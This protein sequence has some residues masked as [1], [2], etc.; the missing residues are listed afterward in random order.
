MLGAALQK[1]LNEWSFN[2][3]A[4]SK[5]IPSLGVFDNSDGEQ[6][7]AQCRGLHLRWAWSTVNM[8]T[9]M[10]NVV[11]SVTAVFLLSD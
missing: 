5:S 6:C 7:A 10:L 4:A 3:L 2:E 9:A 11:L 1:K 8:W